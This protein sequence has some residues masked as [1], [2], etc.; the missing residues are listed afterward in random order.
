MRNSAT[1]QS[2]TLAEM[3]S[4]NDLNT[5]SVNYIVINLPP[6]STGDER[7]LDLQI[8]T[9]GRTSFLEKGMVDGCNEVFNDMYDRH[10]FHMHRPFVIRLSGLLKAHA[11][12]LLFGVVLGALLAGVMT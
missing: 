7:Y 6:S 10:R 2:T 12:S 5:D 11:L 9:H 3:I 8:M 1:S 4:G